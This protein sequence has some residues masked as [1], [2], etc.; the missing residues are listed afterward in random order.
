MSPHPFDKH[1]GYR[2]RLAR[3]ENNMRQADLAS[4]LNVSFQQVQKYERGENRTSCS[5]LYQISQHLERPMS[6]FLDSY[7]EDGS[8]GD[9]N[10]CEGQGLTYKESDDAITLMIAYNK[11]ES[12]KVQKSLLAIAK[13]LAETGVACPAE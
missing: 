9:V 12:N 5:R 4:A 1:V 2:I 3:L 10:P 13:G 11:I 7:K 6:Y 8:G